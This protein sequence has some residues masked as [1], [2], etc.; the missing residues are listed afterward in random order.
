MAKRAR[1]VLDTN[2]IISGIVFGGKPREVLE[3]VKSK[4]IEGVISPVLFAELGEVLAKKFKYSKRRVLQVEKK[5]KQ[6]FKIVHPIK[7]INAVR[8]SDDNRVIEAAVEGNCGYIVTGD[9]DLLTLGKYK[10][11]RILTTAEFLEVWRG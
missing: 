8:D 5:L 3:L 11:V 9:E 4:E 10:G 7:S 2:V 6:I 1:I